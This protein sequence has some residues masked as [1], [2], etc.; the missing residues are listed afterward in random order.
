MM[1]HNTK[2][3]YMTTEETRSNSVAIGLLES[4]KK[5]GETTYFSEIIEQQ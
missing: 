4:K 1:P 2:V 5:V 3:F